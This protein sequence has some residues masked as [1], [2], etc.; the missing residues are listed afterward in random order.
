MAAGLTSFAGNANATSY[1]YNDTIDLGNLSSSSGFT[2]NLSAPA[3]NLVHGD[4]IS[5]TISFAN[6]K[7]IQVNN[8]ATKDFYL[9]LWLNPSTNSTTLSHTTLLSYQGAEDP[10]QTWGI[11]STSGPEIGLYQ[12]I[13][14]SS[15]FSFSGFSYTT[16]FDPNGLSSISTSGGAILKITTTGDISAVPEPSTYALFGLGALAMVIAARRRAF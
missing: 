1:V 6:N 11:G 12:L 15:N 8:V 7:S 9:D 10:N 3:F 16:T 14:A 4:T 5:G 13:P 2:W